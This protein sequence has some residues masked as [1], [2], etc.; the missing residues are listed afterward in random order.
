MKGII[1]AAGR[2]SRM[3]V[4]TND[5]PKCQ[6]VV[7]GKTLLDWQLGSLKSAGISQVAVVTGY[8]SDYL[9]S[10][11][12]ETFHNPRWDET[13]MLVSLM[14][15]DTWLSQFPCVISYADILY[16]PDIVRSLY[17][18]SEHITITYD[19]MWES[20]WRLRFSNPLSDAET[21]KVDDG[22]YLVT[23][24]QRAQ[25]ISEIQGQYMGLIKTTPD[26][27]KV[28]KE[29]ILELTSKQ[30]DR[31]DMTGMFAGLLERCCP[32]KAIAIS[33]RW[34]EVDSSNDLFVYENM[35]NSHKA[36]TH[37]WRE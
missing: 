24:G 27:W 29:L 4:V 14:T 33:G 19:L 1:L 30:L 32:I 17:N 10:P 36:W 7:A 34:C 13:N 18:D 21:F 9:Q 2:G 15:A 31:L 23:I 37:D 12:Y 25:C 6:I 11:L 3:G 8:K 5:L 22:D 20:L 26:S 35:I 28:I 16:H